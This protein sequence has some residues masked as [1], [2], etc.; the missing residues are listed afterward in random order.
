MHGHRISHIDDSG[1]ARFPAALRYGFAAL[2]VV[3]L[4]VFLVGAFTGDEK[5]QT[6]AWVGFL[7][8]YVFFFFLAMGA[9]AFLAIQYVVG[10]RWFVVLKRLPESIA[11]FAWRGGFVFPLLGLAG[12]GL[13]YKWAKPEKEYPYAGTL[14][15]AWLSPSVHAVKVVVITGI[16]CGLTYFLTSASTRRTVGD[17]EAKGSRLR[18]S[19]LFLMVYAFVF[20]LFSWDVIMSLEP[21]FFSTMYGV[22]CFSG[23]FLSA[24]A[25]MMLM[26]YWLRA[27][28]PFLQNRHMYDMGTYVMAFATFMAYIG[29]SQFMLIWYANIH[30]ETFYYIDRY[31]A[32]WWEASILLA[33]L[34]F[35]VPFFVLM[36]SSLRTSGFAQTVAC[37]AVLV[38]QALDV[39]WLIAPSF[40]DTFLWPSAIN[41]M[42]F[43]GVFGFFGWS[44]LTHLSSHSLVPVED[45]DLLASVNGDYL[46]A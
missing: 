24:I 44:T 45:D 17:T 46:H 4:I 34:K 31:Q 8:S 43:L 10:A 36:P 28:S 42:T 22:Y 23:A 18:T 19:I 33:I 16:L 2:G 30:D 25:V 14:K 26:T 6:Q 5:A 11:S 35:F 20:S 15:E 40:S 1:P 9:A 41:V 37:S 32:G 13:L 7:A 12:T 38:G 27:R 21:K 3:G 29:F 39:W